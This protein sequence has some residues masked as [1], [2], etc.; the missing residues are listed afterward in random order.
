MSKSKKHLRACPALGRDITSA[1]CGGGRGSAYACPVECP[2]FPFTPANYEQHGEIESRLISKTYERAAKLMSPA[3]R[4]RMLDE[5]ED[6]E[7]DEVLANHSRFAWLYH[8]ERDA[9]GRTFGERWLADRMSGLSNDERVL[10]AGMNESRPVVFKVERIL[11]AQMVEGVDL[12]NRQR[13]S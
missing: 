11:D 4:E 3:E 10:L 2:F 8:C 1:E 13:W 7:G 9:E 6:Q 12:L 5:I